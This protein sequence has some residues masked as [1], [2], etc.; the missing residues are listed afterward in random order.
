MCVP[1]TRAAGWGSGLTARPARSPERGIFEFI[2]RK[3]SRQNTWA[4]ATLGASSSNFNDIFDFWGDA[5]T[6]PTPARPLRA[7]KSAFSP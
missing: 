4:L 5:P 2:G 7:P 1:R 3:W 6:W